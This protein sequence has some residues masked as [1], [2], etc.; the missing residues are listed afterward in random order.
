MNTATRFWLP[1]TLVILAL[2]CLGLGDRPARRSVSPGVPSVQ[3]SVATPRSEVVALPR[4]SHEQRPPIGSRSMAPTR[5]DATGPDFPAT[6]LNPEIGFRVDREALEWMPASLQL[7]TGDAVLRIDGERLVSTAQLVHAV[8]GASE[9]T[10]FELRVRRSGSGDE[11]TY[12][13]SP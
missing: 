3:A 9:G 5:I 10:A 8:R 13:V 6:P 2:A 4:H 11:V 7:R 1:L 12:W